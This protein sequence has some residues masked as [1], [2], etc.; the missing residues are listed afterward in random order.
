MDK[1][2]H[3]GLEYASGTVLTIATIFGILSNIVSVTYFLTIKT[4]NSN[5]EFFRRL[6]SLIS[7]NDT[8]LCVSM[9]PA[10]EA[11]FSANRHGVMYPDPVFCSVWQVFQLITIQ[12]SVVLTT[13][14]SVSRLI[15]I[16]NP[17]VKLSPRYVFPLAGSFILAYLALFVSFTASGLIKAVYFAEPVQCRWVQASVATNSS[18]ILY[19]LRD[20]IVGKIFL[21]LEAGVSSTC[22]FVVC[23]SV[24]AS[25][26][27]LSKPN[28]AQSGTKS[29]RKHQRRA[30]ITVISM[31]SLY[32][33]F[34]ALATILYF[35]L[36]LTWNFLDPLKEGEITV[37]K[38]F[39][40]F[41]SG[42]FSNEFLSQYAIFYVFILG[43]C[44]NSAINPIIYY[45]RVIAYKEYV[46]SLSSSVRTRMQDLS[47]SRSQQGLSGDVKDNREKDVLMPDNE[48]SVNFAGG[49]AEHSV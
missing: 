37:D 30:A 23:I 29:P 47:G 36:F 4:R 5:N 21:S 15:L 28:N 12:Y 11:V 3:K 44:L 24:V 14:L 48:N 7:L 6:Y 39:M 9:V 20:R 18:T 46:L 42:V 27:Y 35:Y 17:R 41:S 26:V 49:A 16:R 40:R 38:V 45:H 34:N 1:F 32:I 43:T 19:T 2:P 22:F 13:V 33:T 25:L 8:L 10:I 31:T